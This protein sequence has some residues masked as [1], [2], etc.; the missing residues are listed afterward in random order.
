MPALLAPSGLA[1]DCLGDIDGQTIAGAI[2]TGTHGTGLRHPSIG[3]TV[4]AAT[5]VDGRGELV[6]VSE[7]E[8]PELLLM[9]M[10]MYA[11]VGAAE[12]AGDHEFGEAVRAGCPEPKA[13]LRR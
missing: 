1:M 8:R 2:S 7:T 13:E 3:A 11:A 10:Q 6:R 5:L 4:V 9:Q 12:E